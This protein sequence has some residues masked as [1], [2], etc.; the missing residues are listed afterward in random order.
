[1]AGAAFAGPTNLLLGAKA[2]DSDGLV[3][4]VAFYQDGSLIGTVAKSPFTLVWTNVV[5]G[6][7]TLT[8]Q[9][10]DDLG[11]M[12]TSAPVNIT[13]GGNIAAPAIRQPPLSQTVAV[14]GR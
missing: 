6:S 9:A 3:Q 7:Y 1:M 4:Q 14:G 11:L 10:A 12:T 2:S 8:A 5:A 13:V